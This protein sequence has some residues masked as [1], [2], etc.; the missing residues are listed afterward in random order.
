[1]ELQHLPSRREAPIERKRKGAVLI[2]KEGAAHEKGR[3][4]DV[5]ISGKRWISGRAHVRGESLGVLAERLTSIAQRIC[6]GRD[7]RW[8]RGVEEE[9]CMVLFKADI[10]KTDRGF[11]KGG[12]II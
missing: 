3:P 11:W 5:F 9:L 10:E 1:M 6:R 4:T 8:S 7:E 12:D 2:K